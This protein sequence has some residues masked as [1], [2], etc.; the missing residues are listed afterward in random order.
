MKIT[1]NKL[2]ILIKEAISE[3]LEDRKTEKEVRDLEKSFNPSNQEDLEKAKELLKMLN[4][5]FRKGRLG[6]NG[7]KQIMA[8]KKLIGRIPTAA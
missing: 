8:L 2:S 6:S 5:N 4:T 3:A 1:K 7:V